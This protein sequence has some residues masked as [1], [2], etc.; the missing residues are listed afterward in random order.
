M[1]NNVRITEIPTAQKKAGMGQ[2]LFPFKA[3]QI[4][5]LIFSV[6]EGLIALRI[7]LKLIGAK[8]E[9]PMVSLIYGATTLFLLPFAGLISSPAIDGKVLEISSMFAIVVYALTALA[10]EKLIRV[11]F[12]RPRSAVSDVSETATS[13]HHIA[14]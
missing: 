3:T 6:L 5:L 13:E 4:I 11:I 1:S 8:P 14:P 10:V 7:L 2:R 12:S 9:S